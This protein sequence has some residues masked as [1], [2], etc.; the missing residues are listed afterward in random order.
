MEK[1]KIADYVHLV[2][3]VPQA[4]ILTDALH[5]ILNLLIILSGIKIDI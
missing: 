3:H 2:G 5:V 1:V 4:E